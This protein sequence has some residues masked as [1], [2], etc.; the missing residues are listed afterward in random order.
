MLHT[1]YIY[2]TSRGQFSWVP[3]CSLESPDTPILLNCMIGSNVNH[4]FKMGL[5]YDNILSLRRPHK[6][7]W[8]TWEN[9]LGVQG[10]SYYQL[11]ISLLP[12][13][14]V[15][16]YITF[17]YFYKFT[18]KNLWICNWDN[19]QIEPLDKWKV[20]NRIIYDIA[21][22]INEDIQMQSAFLCF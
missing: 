8:H 3:S 7:S 5:F 6:T 16:L 22:C 1:I 19:L 14:I 13:F 15:F 2:S 11:T 21:I 10:R 9:V 4:I 20:L 17:L 12:R 18:H